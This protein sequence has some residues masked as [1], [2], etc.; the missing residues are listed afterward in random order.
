M[1]Q[2]CHNLVDDKALK[3]QD[4]KNEYLTHLTENR[5]SSPLHAFSL[6]YLNKIY[7][8]LYYQVPLDVIDIK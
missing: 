6:G 2:F 3:P 5:I 7:F 4:L 8:I 1:V